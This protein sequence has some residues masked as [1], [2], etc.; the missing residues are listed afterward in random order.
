MVPRDLAARVRVVNVRR[1]A[2]GVDGMTLGRFVLVR[3]DE[4]RDG[5]RGL[6]VH[7]LVHVLQWHEQGR[8]GFL[9]SYLWAYARNL[10]RLRRHWAAYEA[11]PQEVEARRV[12]AE[13]ASRRDAG[14]LPA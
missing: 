1:L 13:W 11:I 9:A 10:A 12:A 2:P 6:L 14:R 4:D 7:E 3:A 5:E 8:I